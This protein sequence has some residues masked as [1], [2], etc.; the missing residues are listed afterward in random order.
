M[1]ILTFI[2]LFYIIAKLTKIGN[3]QKVVKVLQEKL[4]CCFKYDGNSGAHH[5]EFEFYFVVTSC[6]VCRNPLCKFIILS[7]GTST[8]GYMCSFSSLTHI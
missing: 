3:S 6:I 2:Q 7:K 4:F 5:I 8:D 1:S